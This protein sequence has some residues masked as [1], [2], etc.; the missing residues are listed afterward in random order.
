MPFVLVQR[1][2]PRLSLAMEWVTAHPS[3]VGHFLGTTE[4]GSVWAVPYAEW[5]DLELE[6]REAEFADERRL[7]QMVWASSVTIGVGSA[8]VVGEG[9][10]LRFGLAEEVL[11]S[12]T[13]A[14]KVA[15]RWDDDHPP[16][17]VLAT[18]VRST[19]PLVPVSPDPPARIPGVRMVGGIAREVKA[20]RSLS[21]SVP[22]IRWQDLGGEISLLPPPVK[23]RGGRASKSGVSPLLD[24]E[25]GVALPQL[26]LFGAVD[27]GG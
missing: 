21:R 18:H 11:G 3:W 17:A 4:E 9:L 1:L 26:G 7:F 6:G 16:S 15:V 2:P 20:P 22:G 27:D 8:I 10:D 19:Q 24:S 5:E 13:D 14:F 12:A 23:K 25:A